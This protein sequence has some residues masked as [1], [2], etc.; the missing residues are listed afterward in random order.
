MWIWNNYFSKTRNQTIKQLNFTSGVNFHGG[1]SAE[2]ANV[3]LLYGI[4]VTDFVN[5]VLLNGT[6]QTFEKTLML[7]SCTVKG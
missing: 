2:V 5:N 1:V 7:E 4:N 3:G 6:D